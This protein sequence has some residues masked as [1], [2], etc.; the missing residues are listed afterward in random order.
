MKPEPATQVTMPPC[1]LDAEVAVLGALLLDQEAIARVR[2]ELSPEDFFREHHGQI[3]RAALHLNDQGE[4]VDNITL[5]AELEEMGVLDNLGGRARLAMLQE[6]TPTAANVEH[7][8]RIVRQK[9]W[10]RRLVTTAEQ[11]AQDGRALDLGPA[12]ILALADRIREVAAAGEDASDDA[13]EAPAMESTTFPCEVLP[14]ALQELA[15]S[16]K[17]SFGYPV[18]FVAVPGLSVLAAAV[19]GAYVLQAMGGWVSR[20]ILWTAVVAPPGS[21]KTPAQRLVTK[22]LVDIDSEL[23]TAY[24]DAL[25]AHQEELMGLKKGEPGPPP[26]TRQ[27]SRVADVNI[28]AL[29]R[30]LRENERRGIVWVSNELAAIVGGLDQNRHGQGSERPRFMELWDGDPWAVDRIERG[31]LHIR[32]PLVSVVGGLVPDRIGLLSAG[33]G[34]GARFLRT[35]HPRVGMAVSNPGVPLR[36]GVEAAWDRLVRQLVERQDPDLEPAILTLR[37]DAQETWVSFQN[38]LQ[39][40]YGLDTTSTFGQEVIAKSVEQMLRL[41]LVLHCASNPQAVPPMIR[42]ETVEDAAQLARYFATQALACQPD[43]PSAA[44]DRQTRE[45]DDG[46]QKLVR[47]LQRRRDSSGEPVPWATGRDIQRAKIAG[48]KTSEEVDRVLDRYARVYPGCV[49]AGRAPG[50]TRGRVG[51]VVYLTEARP[52]RDG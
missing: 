13:G 24:E 31:S 30:V 50:A 36:D 28:A 2:D 39:G 4:P 42:P 27:R 10:Q 47:W 18:E 26:P 7:Y 46:V 45:L 12:E 23:Y 6:Q 14:E 34:M 35:F 33:D 9:A 29:G 22:P 51:R 16:A 44:A 32:H 8:A 19:G 49:V 20:P 41:A 11:V 17:M 1:D 5:A 15:L 40:F 25:A 43:E 3:F 37:P 21:A 48:L 38:E 52:G